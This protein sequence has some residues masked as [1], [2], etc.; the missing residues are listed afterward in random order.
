M[1]TGTIPGDPLGALE[2]VFATFGEFTGILVV[3]CGLLVV[4]VLT[5]VLANYHTTT[6]TTAVKV[7]YLGICFFYQ[8]SM[9]LSLS[10]YQPGIWSL[11]GRSNVYDPLHSCTCHTL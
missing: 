9:S 2:L 1:N 8:M 10:T 4:P 11:L 6:F 7:L 5:A 3:F